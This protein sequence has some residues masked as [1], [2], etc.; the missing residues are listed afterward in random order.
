MLWKPTT[1]EFLEIAGGSLIVNDAPNVALERFT[2]R[3]TQV[4]GC[5]LERVDCRG[6]FWAECVV[7]KLILFMTQLVT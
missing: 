1:Y 3:Q 7:F 4:V 2:K 6:A 5:I